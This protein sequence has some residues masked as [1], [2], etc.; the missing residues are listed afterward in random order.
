M[1]RVSA[2]CVLAANLVG[3]SVS[4]FA[5][6]GMGSSTV[7]CG[8]WTVERKNPQSVEAYMD[9]SWI[10]GFLSGIGF[11]AVN[12]YDPLVGM[13]H[14]GVTAWIDNYCLSNPTKNISE[15]AA[16]FFYFHPHK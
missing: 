1:R 16:E 10:L 4:T 13:D 14:N 8:T 15:A 12:K 2:G 9:K 5:Y 3:G 6:T 7:S 11:I